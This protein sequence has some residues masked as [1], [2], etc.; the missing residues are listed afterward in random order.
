MEKQIGLRP[1]IEDTGEAPELTD[2]F[3]R[4]EPFRTSVGDA[5]NRNLDG[6]ATN[7]IE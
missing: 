5:T 1:P 2:A 4:A 6:D 3:G 7:R